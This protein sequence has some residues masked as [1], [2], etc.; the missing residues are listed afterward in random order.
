MRYFASFI[1]NFK[2]LDVRSGLLHPVWGI[3][4]RDVPLEF[5]D[6]HRKNGKAKALV[7]GHIVEFSFESAIAAG[8]DIPK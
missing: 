7:W 4:L 2:C 3:F 8:Q 5:R 6:R 1:L